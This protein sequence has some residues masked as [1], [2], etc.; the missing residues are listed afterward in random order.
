VRG[1]EQIIKVSLSSDRAELRV[2]HLFF[3]GGLDD[4]HGM[5]QGRRAHREN[6]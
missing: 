2:H 6:S 3:T 4:D 1:A 5:S